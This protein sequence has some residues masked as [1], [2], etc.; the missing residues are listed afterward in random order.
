M[1]ADQHD[2]RPLFAPD[3]FL[4]KTFHSIIYSLLDHLALL[5]LF[6]ARTARGV[7]VATMILLRRRTAESCSCSKLVLAAQACV[8]PRAARAYHFCELYY[9]VCSAGVG[10][11]CPL[12]E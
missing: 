1:V 10:A 12:G 3:A 4:H 8:R 7:L 9:E 6:A 11:C 2:Q 5:V